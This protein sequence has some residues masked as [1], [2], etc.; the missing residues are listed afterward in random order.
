MHQYIQFILPKLI[1]QGR[2][3]NVNVQETNDKMLTCKT[4]LNRVNGAKKSSNNI[5]PLYLR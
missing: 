4:H 3:H 1:I 2:L 5:L